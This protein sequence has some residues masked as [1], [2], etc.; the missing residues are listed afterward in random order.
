MT[1]RF[2]LVGWAL[3]MVVLAMPLSALGS[4]WLQAAAGHC[5]SH[6][7]M[8]GG[9]APSFS[10]QKAPADGSCCQV[11]AARPAPA[12]MAQ[13][14]GVGGDVAPTLIASVLDVPSG[15]AKAEP[16]DPLARASC[17]SLQSVFC[18]FL[19]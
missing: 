2:K 19:I 5:T 6:C 8:M 3:V 1:C 18:T 9:H 13:V 17:P 7:P 15:P 12:P 16:P 4:C 14:P 10:M 11:S